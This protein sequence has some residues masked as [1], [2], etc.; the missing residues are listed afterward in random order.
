M[1]GKTGCVVVQSARRKASNCDVF[2]SIFHDMPSPCGYV[3]SF[4]GFLPLVLRFAFCELL[5]EEQLVRR[6]LQVCIIYIYRYIDICIYI[7]VYV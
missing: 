5:S 4:C 6:E 3:R 2:V 7:Y 1:V